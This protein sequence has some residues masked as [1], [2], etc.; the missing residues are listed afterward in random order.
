MTKNV[1]SNYYRLLVGYQREDIYRKAFNQLAMTIFGLSF[2]DWYQAGYWKEKYI[3]YTLFEDNQA[4]ANV[5]VNLLDFNIHGQNVKTVQIGTVMTL[6]SHRNQKLNR[7]IMERVLS[8]WNDEVSF[9]YLYANSSVLN[10]YPKYGFR[11]VQEYV[12]FDD[13]SHLKNSS[14]TEHP[15]FRKLDMNNKLEQDLLYQLVNQSVSYSQV[16]MH[17]NNDLV[18]FYALSFLKNCIYYFAEENVIVLASI[19]NQTLKI[20]D[21]FGTKIIEINRIIKAIAPEF[22]TN[23]EFGFTPIH[24]HVYRTKKQIAEDTL[25]IKTKNNCIFDYEKLMLPLLSHA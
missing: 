15:S 16:A 7:Y 14:T 4:I 18:M 25:F 11:K 9:I 1:K 12:C 8:D 2:E 6:E 10:L 5:S 20:W 24:S 22:I 3:P 21:I 13:I 17:K 19:D 23:I